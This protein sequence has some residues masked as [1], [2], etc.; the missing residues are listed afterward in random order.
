MC[1]GLVR[2]RQLLGGK[3][4]SSR[5]LAA[6]LFTG[7]DQNHFA[8]NKFWR[9]F[10]GLD[11]LGTETVVLDMWQSDSWTQ[12]YKQYCLGSKVEAWCTFQVWLDI[13]LKS[14]TVCIEQVYYLLFNS[15]TGLDTQPW[16]LG[17]TQTHYTVV[18]PR[19]L[20]Y[21]NY[22]NSTVIRNNVRA[23]QYTNEC[24]CINV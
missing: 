15:K 3:H 23:R 6:V 16:F 12:Q 7:L 9:T 20:C 2:T 17:S 18:R 19:P 22:L 11:N 1:V 10:H 24:V 5:L 13:S 14:A 21:S 8:L 4:Y